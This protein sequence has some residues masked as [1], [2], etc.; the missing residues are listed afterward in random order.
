MGAVPSGDWKKGEIYKNVL[1]EQEL[2]PTGAINGRRE[3]AD[4]GHFLAK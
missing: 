4:T 3:H 1:R 2:Q